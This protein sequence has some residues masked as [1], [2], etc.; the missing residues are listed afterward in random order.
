M[1]HFLE[2]TCPNCRHQFIWLEHTYKGSIYTVY[3]R[4]GYDEI[5]ESTLCPK[6]NIEMVVLK[7]SHIGIDIRDKSIEVAGTLRGI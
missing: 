3:K 6:C 4:I 1:Y 5:L 7:D 2:L